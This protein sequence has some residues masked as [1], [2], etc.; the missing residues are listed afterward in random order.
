MCVRI[1]PASPRLLVGCANHCTITTTIFAIKQLMKLEFSFAVT[2][3]LLPSDRG[4]TSDHLRMIHRLPA[5]N[6]LYF[7]VYKDGNPTM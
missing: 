4:Q 6:K 5:N 2:G 7:Y 1:D 3:V